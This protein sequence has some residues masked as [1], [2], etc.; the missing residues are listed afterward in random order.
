[1]VERRHMQSARTTLLLAFIEA[2]DE[3]G[4]T[5][6]AV[7]A[8]EEDDDGRTAEIESCNLFA[9]TGNT[10]THQKKKR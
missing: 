2:F 6:V 5:D 10:H 4:E 8:G 1:M 7:R 3:G 9:E